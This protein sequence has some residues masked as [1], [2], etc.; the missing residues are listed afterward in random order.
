ML[1]YVQ[2]RE[3]IEKYYITAGNIYNWDEKGFLIGYAFFTKRIMSLEAYQSGRIQYASEDGS[4][5]FVTLL[6]CISVDGTA[7]PP[8]LIYH[9]DLGS[10]Q[11]TW[12][13]TGY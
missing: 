4:M 1:I 6:A 10:L 3:A 11:D 8:A 2:L 9:G 5:E 13:K 7:L 12:V